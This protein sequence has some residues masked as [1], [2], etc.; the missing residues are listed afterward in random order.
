MPTYL[1]ECENGHEY[2]ETRGMS[3]DQKQSICVNP[4]CG[5]KLIR[6]FSA[7][8]ISFKG[9]GFNATRG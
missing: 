1:Y 2:E 7:P 5:A 4:G 3:E 6:K 8:S 9:T